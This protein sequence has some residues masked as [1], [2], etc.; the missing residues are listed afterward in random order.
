MK[1][2]AL[3]Q[4]REFKNLPLDGYRAMLNTGPLG[5]EGILLFCIVSCSV[6]E[7]KIW[8]WYYVSITEE[9]RFYSNHTGHGSKET[10]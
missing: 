9:E 10:P 3:S 4:L 5:G 8:E 2:K 7:Q 1:S 6:V